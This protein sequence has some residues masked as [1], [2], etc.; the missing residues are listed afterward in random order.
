VKKH[1]IEWL[2]PVPLW[3]LALADS[4]RIRFQRPSVLRFDAD[5]FMD[6]LTGALAAA[7]PR[8]ADYVVRPETWEEP[9]A[10]WEEEPSPSITHPP[11]LFQPAHGRFYFAA[12]SLVCRRI[13]MPPR[14]V[15]TAAGESTSMVV[16]RLVPRPGVDF[17]P[18]NPTTFD[19]YA[20]AGN[21][22][23]GRWKA[24]RADG[25]PADDEERLPMFAMPFTD[26]EGRKRQLHAAMIPVAGR[27]LYEGSTPKTSAATSPAPPPNPS[28]PMAEMADHRK[29]LWAEGPGL[30]L[31]TVADLASNP[32]L[33][34]GA[35]RDLLRFAMLDLAD[36]LDE[37]LSSL[38]RAVAAS[39]PTGLS[40]TLTTV[41]NSLGAAIPW[42][43]DWRNAV[44]AADA[45]RD[46]L[47]NDSA[48]PEG[49][50]PI[51]PDTVSID[52]VK[53]AAANLITGGFFSSSLFAAFD[54]VPISDRPVPVGGPPVAAAS[55]V[56]EATDHGDGA[57]YHLRCLYERPGCDRFIPPVVSKP[58][59]PFQLSSFFDPTA[60]ARPLT[61]RMPL[62]TSI[63]GLKK[64]P[65]GV[66]VLLSN[67]LRQQVERVQNASLEQLD[68]GD[69]P[70]N[71][72][73]WELGM[74]C[75]LSIPIITIC[76]LI[77]L[78]I[79]VQLLNI[80]FWWL[81]FFKI[82]LPIPVRND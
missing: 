3:D 16:R 76:A 62:D 60:P 42:G 79:I 71:E 30:S 29:A 37:E 73:S 66:S 47:L 59:R 52:Q 22:E 4:T 35:A 57:F 50:Q 55:A 44:V 65:K 24:A 61:I 69:I 11:K 39:S 70:G 32:D 75:S 25:A 64:F 5:A 26:A 38:W 17:E 23:A 6:E 2:S 34:V 9:A 63:K 56:R 15:K 31:G 46:H 54:E 48:L 40:P 78:M 1:S 8:L 20:W 7:P 18:D 33:T 72:P 77:L 27:E 19:E 58:S 36:L 43:G 81:P 68:E 13:G 28:D 82:C 12:A 74:I 80:V 49:T 67:K 14:K 10:G 45:Q 21:R 53:I 41:F 51:V